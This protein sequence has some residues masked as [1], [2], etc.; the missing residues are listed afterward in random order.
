MAGEHTGALPAPAEAAL[1]VLM[2]RAS[3]LDGRVSNGEQVQVDLLNP[4]YGE[5][6]D[7]VA[8][9]W[10]RVMLGWLRGAGRGDVFPFR[11]EL[12]P[13]DYAI[14]GQGGREI[15]DRWAQQKAMRD[16]V[17]RLWNEAVAE[18]G[19]GEPHGAAGGG[20]P[21]ELVDWVPYDGNPLFAG[22]GQ[23]TW[24]DQIRERGFIL[25]EGGLWRLWY[26]GY[27][28]ARGGSMALGYATSPDGVRFTRHSAN[29]AFDGVW[30]EDVF[31]VPQAGGYEMFAEG[32]NDIAHRLT[33]ADGVA[34]REVG[35]LDV[36][37]RSGAPLPPGPY[38]TP[39]VVVEGGTWHLF[40]E[41]EDKGVWLAT[42]TDRRV[43]TNVS[44]EPVI[45]LGPDAYDRH[46]IALNQVVRYKGRY[47]GVYHANADPQWKGPWT[48][49]LAVSDDL[50]HWR[51]YPGNPIVRSD[52]SSGILVDDGERLRLY[53]MH[54]QVKLW[55]PRGTPPLAARR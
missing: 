46:A 2:E 20:F 10:K 5:H 24:D 7:R 41:R 50:V 53:T 1:A 17:E 51:K 29:P 38:G 36:R 15:S 22:T 47:Y 39:S 48:T 11:V 16:L 4:V 23:G 37:T 19:L 35:P 30:T 55:L 44:D 52:D 27:N 28:S 34:W 21:K 14:L 45:P 32:T 13:P 9:L 18:T 25:R 43:W 31:V 8:A 6:V 12:G 3:M 42:S 40:Y 26:T 33:S 54:P 49:C